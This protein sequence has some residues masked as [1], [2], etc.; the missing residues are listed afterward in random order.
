MKIRSPAGAGLLINQRNKHISH[1]WYTG[2]KYCAETLGASASGRS[3][4]RREEFMQNAAC[5]QGSTGAQARARPVRV[6]KAAAS[7]RKSVL[8][9]VGWMLNIPLYLLPI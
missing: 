6:A 2:M 9:D 5:P 7:L 8:A 1:P 4:G 3:P